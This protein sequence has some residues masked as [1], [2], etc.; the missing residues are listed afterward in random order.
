M[1]GHEIFSILK[2]KGYAVFGTERTK[3]E[4]NAIFL[5]LCDTPENIIAKIIQNKPTAV[6]NCA[7]ILKPLAEHH[8]NITIQVNSLAP[9]L[10]ANACDILGAKLIHITTDCVY[11]GEK[12]HYTEQDVPSPSD[13]YGIS[14]LA[15]EIVTNEIVKS[16]HLNI[17][18]SIIGHEQRLEKYN[19]LDWFLYTKNTECT[20]FTNHYWNGLTTIQLADF[21]VFIIQNHFSLT[22][23]LHVYGDTFTKCDLLEIFKEVY[24][25][26]IKINRGASSFYCNR[27]LASIRFPS[28]NYKVPPLKQ[29]LYLLKSRNNI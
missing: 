11:D 23:T 15:G 10:L 20:G 4:T 24:H 19:L 7:G 5:D 2:E 14:K 17:R 28:L 27:T 26:D 8:P 21:L 9:H 12:G 13:F 29:Q 1:L 16:P 22:G 18:T 3:K 6:I 25:K